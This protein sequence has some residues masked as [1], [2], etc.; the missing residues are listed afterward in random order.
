[1]EALPLLAEKLSPQQQELLHA[2][3][4]QPGFE[5]LIQLFDDACVSLTQ[6]LIKLNPED[7]DYERKLRELHL[8]SRTVNEFCSAVRKAIN[9][10]T[11]AVSQRRK[12]AKDE[13]ERLVDAAVELLGP[14]NPFGSKIIKQSGE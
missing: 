8:Q 2:L 10:H 14:G 12:N 5:V 13:E 7:V 1:M 4:Y 11:S 3:A 6:R 9:F